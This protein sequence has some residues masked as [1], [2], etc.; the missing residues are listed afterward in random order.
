MKCTIGCVFALVLFGY[1][2][3]QDTQS[4]NE[5]APITLSDQQHDEVLEELEINDELLTTLEQK[6]GW[7]VWD[8]VRLG[9]TTLRITVTKH[10]AGNKKTYIVLT[11][12]AAAAV[13]VLLWYKYYG[14]EEKKS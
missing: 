6:G 13:L 12:A 4:I 10:V 11:G 14:K 3:A 8:K 7:G 1:L 9:W 5:S 2:G